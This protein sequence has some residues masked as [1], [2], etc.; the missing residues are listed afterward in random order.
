MDS[1]APNVR[2]GIRMLALGCVSLSAALAQTQTHRIVTA[3]DNFLSTLDE[4]QRQSVLFAF[5]DD[6]QRVRWSNFPI[7]MVPRAGISLKDMNAAQRTAAMGLLTSVLSARGFEKVQEI[8]EGDEVNKLPDARRPPA[9]NGGPRDRNGG[10][11]D[12][13]GGPRPG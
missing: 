12:G 6:R 11:P 9:G 8:M 1:K 5:N 4:T 10:P 2:R 7:V 3:A 13:N